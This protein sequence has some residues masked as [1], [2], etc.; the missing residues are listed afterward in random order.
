[1]SI[2]PAHAYPQSSREGSSKTLRRD[3]E[4]HQLCQWG[5][6]GAR[7]IRWFQVFF[8][9]SFRACRIAFLTV[10]IREGLEVF[11]ERFG[12]VP[13]ADRSA[14]LVR[15]TWHSRQQVGLAWFLSGPDQTQDHAPP[16]T[17]VHHKFIQMDVDL[18][19]GQCHC[20][21]QGQ[22]T[23]AAFLLEPHYRQG[24]QPMLCLRPAYEASGCNTAR[25]FNFK[26]AAIFR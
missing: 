20:C 17:M 19:I 12:L 22:S 5:G 15:A 13:P 7:F 3:S 16:A 25:N 1:M 26:L 9:Q 11:M 10:H 2:V 24:K 4:S 21:T 6:G 23:R 18:M 8:G 14:L